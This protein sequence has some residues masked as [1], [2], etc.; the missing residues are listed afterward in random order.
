MCKVGILPASD[1]NKNLTH[2]HSVVLPI[3]REQ[4]EYVAIVIECQEYP[5]KQ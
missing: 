1:A 4:E 5:G 2:K 3:K